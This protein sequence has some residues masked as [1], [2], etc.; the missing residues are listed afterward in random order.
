MPRIAMISGPRNISTTM[1]RSFG[2]RGDTRVVDEPFYGCYLAATGAPH[3]MREEILAAMKTDW[4]SICDDLAAKAEKATT[5]IQFEKHIAFHFVD[6]APLNWVADTRVF[7]LIRDPAAM[8]ASYKNK[9]DD[10]EP[11]VHSLNIQRRIYDDCIAAGRP[12][13]ILDANDV[14]DDPEGMLRALCQV[15]GIPFDLAMLA[16]EAGTR[17]EDGVWGP[18]WYDAVIASTGFRAARSRTEPLPQDLAKV[19]ER[20]LPGYEFFHSKRLRSR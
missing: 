3:P 15:L 11:I 9:Y 6:K 10:I 5:Q 12:C 1:M 19:A 13:P 7:Q 18:H 4:S 16:W 20:C 17:P 2:S 8:V 14:L